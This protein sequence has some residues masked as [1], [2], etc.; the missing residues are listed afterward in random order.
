MPPS[1]LTILWG[2]WVAQAVLSAI[3]VRKVYRRIDKQ[4]RP[5]IHP[6]TPPAV[7]IVPFKGVD[8]DMEQAVCSLCEQDYPDYELMLVVESEQDPAYE[9]LQRCLTQ[10]PQR[11]A[12]VLVAGEAPTTRGQKV[13]NQLFAI[14]QIEPVDGDQAWVFLD[15]DAIPD[16]RWL[17]TLVHRLNE[18]DRTAV[19]TGY[20]WLVPAPDSGA[21]ARFASVVNSSIACLQSSREKLSQAWGGAMAMLADTARRGELTRRLQGA[22]TD[23]YPITQMTRDLNMRLYFPSRAMVATPVDFDRASFFNFAYRQYVITRVYAPR[24]FAFALANLTLYVAAMFSAVTALF[25]GDWR[26]AAGV[27]AAVCVA[28]QVRSTFRRRVILAALGNDALQKLRATLCIDRW[29]TPLWMTLHWLI[30]LRACFGNILNWRGN[31]YRL[32]GP[33]RVEKIA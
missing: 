18:K 31:R 8:L 1:L 28:D 9:L 6:F 21:W 10:F 27:I 2:A 15:S 33:D 17:R 32:R 30:V 12:R 5:R 3:V 13:H 4:S 11:K 26:V 25:I 16:D 22:I 20:R 14:E 19:V 7:V 24:L 23:D 29:L